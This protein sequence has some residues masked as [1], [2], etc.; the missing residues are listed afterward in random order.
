MRTA[1][2]RRTVLTAS[3]VSLTLLATACGS[4]KAD[5]KADTKPSGA[6]SSAPAAAAVK[7]KTDAEATALVVTQADLPDQIVSAEGAAKAATESAGATVD[8]AECKPLMQAQS[9]QKVGTATGIGRTTTKAKPKEAAADASPE[10][11][12][13]AGLEALG[14][15]QTL[16]SVGSY[17]AKGAEEA[18]AALKTAAAA[19]SGGYTVTEGGEKVKYLDVKPGAAVTA[20][21]EAAAFTLTMDLDD[22]EKSANHFV[23]VRKG[24]ALATFY[25]FGVTAEQPKTVI[26]AQVKKLG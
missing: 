14:A 19:C 1:L 5:T 25:A 18:F 17:D 26:D 21:D 22:G 15:T 4:D 13:K 20:G 8:K 2:V 12:L 23:I 10:D 6:A 7:G 11:K 3:A 9:G 24:N 16:V